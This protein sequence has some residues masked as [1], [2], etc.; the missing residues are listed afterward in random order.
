MKVITSFFAA[1]PAVWS[2]KVTPFNLTIRA[3]ALAVVESSIVQTYEPAEV[4]PA[5]PFRVTALGP[6]VFG[7]VNEPVTT[8]CDV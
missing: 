7:I 8:C 4:N 1:A 6:F 2:V 3:C 5:E